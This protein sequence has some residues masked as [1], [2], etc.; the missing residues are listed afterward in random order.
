MQLN[1]QHVMSLIKSYNS[2]FNLN[3]DQQNAILKSI[4][5][6]K[7]SLI[8]GMPGTG[9][10]FLLAVLIKILSDMNM[11]VIVTSYTNTALDNVINKMEQL[12]GSEI[13]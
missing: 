6:N 1:L 12:F 5:C 7:F 10:T 2:I 8:W 13:D 9:K 11:S 3:E 4:T